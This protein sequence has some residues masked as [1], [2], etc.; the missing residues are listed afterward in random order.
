LAALGPPAG[1]FLIRWLTP[2]SPAGVEAWRWAFIA[3]SAGAAV[4]AIL[5]RIL[6]ESPRWL[7]AVDRHGEA[8]AA[9]D[10]F[11]RS[12]PVV[13]V[14]RLVAPTQL[15][16]G[17]LRSPKPR[18]TTAAMLCLLY[19]LSPWS[20][21]AFPLLS[22]AILLAKGFKLSDALLY[23]GLSTF[24]PVIGTL[25]AAAVVDRV[26]RRSALL[27]CAATMATG[28]IVFVLSDSP[29]WLVASSLV[30]LLGACLYLPTLTTYGA[31]HFPTV[32]RASGSAIAWTLNRVGAAIAPLALLPLLRATGATGI[33]AAIAGAL[34]AGALLL[35]ALPKGLAR[36]SVS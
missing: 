7:A 24:G 21:V 28:C 19:F 9:L 29:G 16:A 12:R 3:G 4:S 15:T 23:V 11:R 17:P 2:I 6:P 33:G 30:F 25:V 20:T 1:I 22:S 34:L 8:Q 5:F 14:S 10:R 36:R 35:L 32:R 13:A 26:D 27:G 31:E 18:R